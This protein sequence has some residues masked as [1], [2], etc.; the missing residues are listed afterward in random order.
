MQCCVL[1]GVFAAEPTYP[2]KSQATRDD[3]AKLPP[4]GKVVSTVTAAARVVNIDNLLTTPAHLP[5][6]AT[7]WDHLATL[8]SASSVAAEV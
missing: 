1:G 3:E 5:H 2:A 6:R 7:M 8:S 4:E